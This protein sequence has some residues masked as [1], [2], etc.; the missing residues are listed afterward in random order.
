MRRKAD[1]IRL[2]EPLAR[3][4]RFAC[5]ETGSITGRE[6]KRLDKLTR[7]VESVEQRKKA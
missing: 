6:A 4:K 7:R 3:T 2:S 5:Q 1:E